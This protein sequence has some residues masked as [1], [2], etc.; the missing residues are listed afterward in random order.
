M[1]TEENLPGGEFFSRLGFYWGYHLTLRST[2]PF[3]SNL[4]VLE[5]KLEL[6]A[7]LAEAVEQLSKD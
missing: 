7:M 4:Y 1:R 2:L 3:V 5:V 6:E